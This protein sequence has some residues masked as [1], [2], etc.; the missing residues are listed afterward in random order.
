[1]VYLCLRI[2]SPFVNVFAWASVL[3][4][5]FHPV[6]AALVRKTGR[7]TLSALL[8]SALVVIA[9]VISLTF[10]AGLAVNQ[11]VALGDSLQQ[12]FSTTGVDTTTP[13]GR[14]YDWLA[15]R[16]GRRCAGG[17]RRCR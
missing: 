1:M 2:L 17:R 9:F 5:T 13:W 11:F 12:T 8:C 10:I 14:A 6:H 15:R 4:I 7:V 3:A 16:L